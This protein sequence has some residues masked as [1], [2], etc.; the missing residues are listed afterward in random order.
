MLRRL[1]ERKTEDPRSAAIYAAIVAASRQPAFYTRFGVEDTLDGRFEMIVIHAA[2]VTARL[3]SGDD[4]AKA[5]SQ[6]V[7]DAMF[8]DLDRGLRE[9]GVSDLKVPKRIR[10]MAEAFYGRAHA[11]RVSLEPTAP[12]G[13]LESVLARNV[14][15]ATDRDASESEADP[16]AARCAVALAA[17][18]RA[19]HTAVE[20]AGIEDLGDSSVFPDAAAFA[21]SDT[22]E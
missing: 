19:A 6:S 17:Y 13:A 22:E 7:F 5:L 10:R 18:M 1:F 14:F 3:S 2:L 11:Y 16:E 12:A 4:D 21:G 9:L 15:G 8:T 20:A